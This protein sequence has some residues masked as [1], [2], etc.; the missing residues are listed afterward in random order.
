MDGT[1]FFDILISTV[2][3]VVLFP[4]LL[5]IALLIIITS[6][7]PAIFVQQRVGKNNINFNIYKFRTMRVNI[8]GTAITI[9][10]DKRITRI[11]RLLRKLKLDELP[12]LFNV[13]KGD[14]SLVGPRP[15][16][17]RYVDMYKPEDMFV[18]SVRPGITDYASLQYRNENELLAK[19]EDPE[20][21]YIEVV[22]PAKLTLNK[23]Y[24]SNK[25][26]K[27]Y[28]FIIFRTILTVF[29]P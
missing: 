20:K 1:R 19:A 26:L 24:I 3:L 9:G 21:F 12:Q 16:I 5:I 15:E 22:M 18:L 27:A 28:F 7:G 23:H 2:L 10:H 11:G 8:S 4:F 13:V 6:K 14:M 29:N 17:R 25:G